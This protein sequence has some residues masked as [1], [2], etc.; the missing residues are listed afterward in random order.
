MHVV[1]QQI[2]THLLELDVAQVKLP[3]RLIGVERWQPPDGCCLKNN[4]DADFHSP[5]K[6]SCAGVVIRNRYGIVLG[7]HIVVCK[8]IPSAFAALPTTCLH[9]VHLGLALGFPYVIIEGDSL[10]EGLKVR[11]GFY[12]CGGVLDFVKRAVEC[13]R[14]SSLRGV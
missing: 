9:A 5:S 1:I 7:S 4:F 10:T 3:R 13:D 8:H 12:M 14:L 11:M 6:I 2:E